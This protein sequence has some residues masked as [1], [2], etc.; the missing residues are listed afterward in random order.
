MLLNDG[1]LAGR[2]VLG[3]K[4]VELMRSPRMDMDGDG[5][6]DF[7]LGVEIVDDLGESG[8]L[9]SNG[10]VSMGWCVRDIL[11]DRSGR[12]SDW[13]IDDAGP[14]DQQRHQGSFQNA[15]LPGTGIAKTFQTAQ[16]GKRPCGGLESLP[17]K[18]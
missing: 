1:E 6:A 17:G 15:G 3:R 5:D 8:E 7:G 16:F 18:F 9:G 2:R 11:L 4:S 10:L 12:T 14:A 13:R